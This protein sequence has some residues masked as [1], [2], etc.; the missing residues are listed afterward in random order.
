[1]LQQAVKTLASSRWR[2][3]TFDLGSCAPTALCTFSQRSAQLTWQLGLLRANS[4]L[5][6]RFM[7]YLWGTIL[8]LHLVRKNLAWRSA[9]L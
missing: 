5:V 8:V 9:K 4:P 1:M 2:S 7:D 6:T 3:P